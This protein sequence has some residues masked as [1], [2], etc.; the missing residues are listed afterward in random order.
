M[1]R[2]AV[3]LVICQQLISAQ[4]TD[5]KKE[6]AAALKACGTAALD[7]IRRIADSREFRFLGKVKDSTALCRGGFKAQQFRLTP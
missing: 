3:A 2:A 4:T 7:G 5:T 1:K 6:Q